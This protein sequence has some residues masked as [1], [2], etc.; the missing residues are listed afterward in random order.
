MR[1]LAFHL[2]D[3]PKSEAADLYKSLHQALFGP[4]HAIPDPEERQYFLNRPT[5]FVLPDEAV[6][7]LREIAGRLLR[8]SP[9]YQ[10][11]V[12]DLGGAPAE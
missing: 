8:A 12:R 2:A 9:E 4:G 7:R 10:A 3:H 6:D 5:S 1:A 11:L